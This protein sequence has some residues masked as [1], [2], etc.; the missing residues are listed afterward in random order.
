MAKE[1]KKCAHV[2]CSCNVSDG[3]KY[4]SAACEGAKDVTELACQCGHTN[5]KGAVLST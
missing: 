3:E 2:S 5:C 1:P 4:C